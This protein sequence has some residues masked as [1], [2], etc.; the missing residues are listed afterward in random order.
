M[1]DNDKGNYVILKGNRDLTATRK[2]RIVRGKSR[3][4]MTVDRRN[5][6]RT[7]EE[8]MEG[9][10]YYWA[11][12]EEIAPSKKKVVRVKKNGNGRKRTRWVGR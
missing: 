3:A 5:R 9:W 8:I 4:E 12:T 6:N 1:L 7:E 2:I 10:Q 11:I